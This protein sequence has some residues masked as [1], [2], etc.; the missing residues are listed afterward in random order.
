LLLNALFLAAATISIVASAHFAEPVF[1]AAVI[2]RN[3]GPGLVASTAQAPAFVAP[4]RTRGTG[5]H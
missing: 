1:D 5:S 4:R 2:S 3:V